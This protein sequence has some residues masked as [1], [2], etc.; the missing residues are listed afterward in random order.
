MV[1]FSDGSNEAF[2]ACA[3]ARWQ[4]SDGRFESRLI[5]AKTRVSPSKRMTIVRIE[6]SGAVLA[7][8]L[9]K[10]LQREMSLDW[11]AT[12]FL[13]DSE[14]VRAMVQKESY[15][16]NTFAAVR[17]GEIQQQT[18]P[19]QWYWIEGR[20]NGSDCLTRGRKPEDLSLNS[21]WQ[22]GPEFLQLPIEQWPVKQTSPQQQLPERSQIVLTVTSEAED[23]LARRINVDRYSKYTKLIRVTARVLA[24]YHKQPALAFKNGTQAPNSEALQAAELFWVQD[25]QA[26]IMDDYKA[27]NFKRLRPRMRE[28]G[29]IVVGGRATNWLELSYNQQELPLLPANH[30]ISLLYVEQV[31]RLGHLGVSAT[32]SKTRE[33]FWIV[34]VNRL[35]KKVRF[36]CVTCK[37]LD[38]NTEGQ[39]MGMLPVERLKPAPAWSHT[40]LD[41]FGPFQIRGE[42]NKR[43]RGKAYG[44]IFNCMISRAVHL[45]LA[46]DYSTAGFMMVFRRFVSLRGYPS[47]LY[48]DSGSQLTA[49]NK[50]LRTAVE[51]LDQ[52]TLR[53][54][55]ADHG[56]KWEFCA[57]DAPWNNGCSE[58]LIKSVKR[59]LQATIGEQVLMFSELQTVMYEVANLLNERPIGRHPT[60]PEDGTYLCPNGLLLGRASQRA[61]SGPW[62]E[63]VNPRHRHEFIQNLVDAYWKKWTRDFFPSLLVSQKW[64]VD[65]RNMQVSDIVIVQDTNLLRGSWRLGRVTKVYEGNDGKVRKV[66]VR[67]RAAGGEGDAQRGGGHSVELTRSVHRLV[68]LVPA[69]GD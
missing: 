17:I 42:V 32:T 4:L 23:S 12:F 21:K 49:A 33:R 9:A 39:K 30:R 44:V 69:E 24:M 14:I 10:F 3:Y 25:A 26:G 5:A 16:F 43:A 35:A 31:H 46:A 56:L 52:E 6:L 40:S 67:C 45:D 34:S 20:M 62:R 18:D 51:N 11:E 47:K 63:T 61:P 37:K 48:S 13:V 8:R 36:E 53:D 41:Y 28:D 55:G 38:K 15:G 1:L 65:R 60:D 54:Y 22:N 64:H 58:A 19:A 68:L 2:G 29:V 59:A 66:D 50:E 57:P 27:G 7:S